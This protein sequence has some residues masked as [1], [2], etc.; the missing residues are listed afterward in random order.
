MFNFMQMKND[1]WE[2]QP[3]ELNSFGAKI[4]DLL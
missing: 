4:E 3:I 1:F 2:K